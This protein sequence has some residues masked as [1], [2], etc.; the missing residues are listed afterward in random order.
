M[1]EFTYLR[2][3]IKAAKKG[4]LFREFSEHYRSY[5]S[6]AGV[7]KAAWMALYEWDLLDD[8]VVVEGGNSISLRLNM[9]NQRGS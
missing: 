2:N 3:A 5:R 6:T 4:G 1:T 9:N 7:R 8:I